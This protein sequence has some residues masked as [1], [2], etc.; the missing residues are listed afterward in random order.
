VKRI[1]THHE[2]DPVIVDKAERLVSLRIGD[3]RTGGETRYALMSP[4][5]A[6]EIAL[7]L[8][9]QAEMIREEIEEQE[10]QTL[11]D[12]IKRNVVR[13]LSGFVRHQGCLP[14]ED[15]PQVEIRSSREMD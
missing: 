1:T 5:T 3:P 7:T 4:S 11:L 9:Q 6:I 13:G 15:G 14:E 12:E 2:K 10:A 8:I